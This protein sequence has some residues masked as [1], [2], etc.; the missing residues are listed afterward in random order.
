MH[1]IIVR[2]LRFLVMGE[3]HATTLAH[4]QAEDVV[5]ALIHDVDEL[6]PACEAGAVDQPVAGSGLHEPLACFV[7]Q[8]AQA[9]LRKKP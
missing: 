8:P 6:A 7:Q 4:D 2:F 9:G 3:A 5:A 1:A